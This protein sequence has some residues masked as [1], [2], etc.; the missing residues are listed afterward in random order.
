MNLSEH[1]MKNEWQ[2]ATKVA[3]IKSSFFNSPKKPTKYFYWNWTFFISVTGMTMHTN[4]RFLC[5]FRIAML[6]V[7]IDFEERK[8]KNTRFY[9]MWRMPFEFSSPFIYQNIK[10]KS[11][12]FW[13]KLLHN[14]FTAVHFILWKITTK[15]NSFTCNFL[16]SLQCFTFLW[17]WAPL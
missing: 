2:S 17:L 14:V 7:D 6:E 13:M 11:F 16:C 10:T 15:P 4:A 12:L 8:T 9:F 5:R 1:L 3:S